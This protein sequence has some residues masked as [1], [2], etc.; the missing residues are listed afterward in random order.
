M[1]G[2]GGGEGGVERKKEYIHTCLLFGVLYN[3]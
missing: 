1:I 3:K 2:G